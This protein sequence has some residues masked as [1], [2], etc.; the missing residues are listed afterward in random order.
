MTTEQITYSRH[1][2]QVE[3]RLLHD[4][5]TAVSFKLPANAALIE[6]LQ[7][8]AERL[9]V[10]LLPSAEQPLDHLHD[11]MAQHEV[12]PTIADLSQPLDVFLEEPGTTHTFGIELVRAFRVNTR[13]S[14]APTAELTPRAILSL[15]RI[16]LDFQNYTLYRPGSVDPLPLDV[17]VPIERG[18]AFEAQRDGKYGS[19]A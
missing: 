5:S 11:V 8:G 6:V 15:P 18:E 3:A 4:G 1:E 12:G 10:R 16:N 7:E 13:W 17:P 2:L 19:E 9:A 14:V